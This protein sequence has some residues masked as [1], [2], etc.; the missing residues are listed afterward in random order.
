MQNIFI[1]GVLIKK[2]PENLKKYFSIALYLKE[3]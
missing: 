2:A 3:N 1:A